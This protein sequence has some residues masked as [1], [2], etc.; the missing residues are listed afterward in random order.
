MKKT[1]KS[2]TAIFMI[3]LT[4]FSCCSVALA[5]KPKAEI[6]V[7]YYDNGNRVGFKTIKVGNTEYYDIFG[8]DGGAV[9]D[10]SVGQFYKKFLPQISHGLR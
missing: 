3:V 8:G 10:L 2:I 7:V 4:I 9:E 1:F 6:E 5:A